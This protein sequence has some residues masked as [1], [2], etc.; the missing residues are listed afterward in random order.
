MNPRADYDL[1]WPPTPGS[2]GGAHYVSSEKPPRD[3]VQ[4][5]REVV[6]E[7]TRGR[8]PAPPPRSPRFR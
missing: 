6:A 3:R 2:V 4:E 7:I 5:L 8:I 1:D